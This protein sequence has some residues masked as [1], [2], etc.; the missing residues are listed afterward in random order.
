MPSEYHL[1][2]SMKE[3][4]KG[5]HYARDEEMKVE[6]M[7]WLKEQSTKFYEAG[8]N[9]L[10]WRWNITMERNCDYVDK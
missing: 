8:I 5:Q 6:R 4:L 1:F 9:A 10:I 3:G 2:G 7:K